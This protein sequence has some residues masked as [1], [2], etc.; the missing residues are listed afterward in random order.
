MVVTGLYELF[1]WVNQPAFH[2]LILDVEAF[3]AKYKN[4]PEAAKSISEEE[5][6][7]L[8]IAFLKMTGVFLVEMLELFIILLGA[9]FLPAP[10]RWYVLAVAPLGWL[11]Y[12]MRKLLPSDAYKLWKH[13]DYAYCV[14]AMLVGPFLY[15]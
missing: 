9:F 8:G 2:Q 1:K 15:L 3:T 13:L 7:V 10:L 14:F 12:Q 4:N 11:S 5:G 6:K